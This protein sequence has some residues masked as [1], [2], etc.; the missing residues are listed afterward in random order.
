V[1]RQQ[2]RAELRAQAK[3]KVVN[4]S[5]LQLCVAAALH[6]SLWQPAKVAIAIDC[7]A[8]EAQSAGLSNAVGG[9]AEPKEKTQ[10]CKGC[11][12]DK[13]LSEFYKQGLGTR[14][15][16]RCKT[17]MDAAAKEPEK[18][19]KP[20]R[21]IRRGEIKP[22]QAFDGMTAA[23]RMKNRL[24]NLKGYKHC[25][26]CG[27]FHPSALYR[28]DPAGLFGRSD[29]C[30]L[31]E[32]AQAFKTGDIM[33][34]CPDIWRQQKPQPEPQQEHPRHASGFPMNPFTGKRQKD[35]DRI[36]ID[37]EALETDEL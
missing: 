28:R 33:P 23:Q 29:T 15:Y 14:T 13:P 12:T 16:N 34:V 18:N 11:K 7:T 37:S 2:R 25:S 31:C 27:R 10:H 20:S 21:P 26:T 32:T 36:V 35:S 6:P 5:A 19:A 22:A 9:A 24:A 3:T 1:T 8:N 17:C 30:H 4:L